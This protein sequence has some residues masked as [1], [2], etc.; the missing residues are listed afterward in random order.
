MWHSL[1]PL[2]R[3]APFALATAVEDDIEEETRKKEQGT[4]L[5]GYSLDSDEEDEEQLDNVHARACLDM[6]RAAVLPLTAA[7]VMRQER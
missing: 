6:L 1:P 4:R 2:R 5:N 3:R 7:R